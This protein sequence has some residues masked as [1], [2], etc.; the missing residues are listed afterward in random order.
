[1]AK[2]A[3]IYTG[4]RMAETPEA[5]Q[6]AVQAWGA[7]FGELGEALIEGGNPFAASATVRADGSV[8]GSGASGIG[9]YS[10]V[11]ADSLEAATTLAKGCP[12]LGDGGTVEVYEAVE[13]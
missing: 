2:Y 8:T 1:M 13:M 10:L 9:G 4:G 11:S 5:R 3:Y 7:W 12:V 6:Q